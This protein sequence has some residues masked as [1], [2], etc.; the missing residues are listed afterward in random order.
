MDYQDLGQGVYHLDTHYIHTG[1]ASLYCV[2][3]NGEAAIV[4]TGTAHSLP[5]VEQ[6]LHHLSIAAEQVKYV[7]PTHVHLDHA[8]GAGVMMQAFPEARLVIHPR[9]ARHM[10]DPQKLV[11]A[12]RAVY[13]DETFEHLYGEIPPIDEARII[14]AEHETSIRLN[15]REFIIVDTPG[16]AYHHFCV[17]DPFSNGVFT[18]D[19][20]G[21]SYPNLLCRNRRFI[22]PTT[23]PTH[24]DPQALHH[25]VDLLMSYKPTQM[26]LTHFN[27]LPDPAEH[28]DQYHEW[29]DKFVDLTERLQPMGDEGLRVMKVEMGELLKQGFELDD[30]IIRGQLAMDIE[31][32]S[33]GLAHWHQTREQS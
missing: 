14:I 22:I 26:Y 24:F 25:S 2:V 6:L 7:I 4:E 16:H 19:T 11:S 30:E 32:N 10:I 15:D 28:I 13:G 1:I 31:L 5:Y 17:V 33:M 18:G 21:L 29:I 20:F 3:H 9:G 27:R 12:T 23:T 8:G